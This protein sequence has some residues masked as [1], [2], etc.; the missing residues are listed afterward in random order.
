MAQSLTTSSDGTTVFVLANLYGGPCRAVIIA[1][2]A[3][4]GEERW[5][6][7]AAG[8]SG[9]CA[10]SAL[11][12]AEVPLSSE[13]GAVV[14]ERLFFTG[15]RNPDAGAGRPVSGFMASVDAHS[16]AIAWTNHFGG[17]TPHGAMFMAVG[18]AP[19]GRTVFGAGGENRADG[20][21][22]EYT[23][24]AYAAGTGEQLWEAHDPVSQPDGIFGNN[25]VI[26]V[27]VSPD[28]QR[29]FVAGSDPTRDASG[30]G[31]SG[32]LTFAHDVATGERL[33]RAR[34]AGPPGDID[35]IGASNSAYLQGALSVSD[36]GTKVMVVGEHLAP[37]YGYQHGWALISYDSATGE[38]VW[39]KVFREPVFRASTFL[40]FS[41][42]LVT[43][44]DMVFVTGVRLFH[45]VTRTVT[46]AYD[47]GTGEQQWMARYARGASYPGGIAAGPGGTVFVAAV[48]RAINLENG[49][50]DP[51]VPGDSWDIEVFSYSYFGQTR[52]QR[53]GL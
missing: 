53:R 41:P 37:M 47:V 10:I 2:D 45:N 48:G 13:S 44:G 18:I 30:F 21:R 24:V 5:I 28:S 3:L 35:T 22:E 17:H 38:P 23:T 8:P 46:A 15:Y 31:R 19:D 20:Q 42:A 25:G 16:G 7:D 9:G 1:Y 14:V 43:R 29:V 32:L 26:D 50:V 6:S 33:W 4:T 49:E 27:A 39:E 52:D 51:Q 34:Y 12:T 36:D 11:V 40:G